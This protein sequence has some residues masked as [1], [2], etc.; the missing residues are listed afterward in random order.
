MGKL[1]LLCLQADIREYSETFQIQTFLGDIK[2][3]KRLD[4]EERS[5]YHLKVYARVRFHLCVSHIGYTTPKRYK[6]FYRNDQE[7][8]IKVVLAIA[9]F[10]AWVISE[11]SH[12]SLLLHK[13]SEC[14][15]VVTG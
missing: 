12:F 10:R 1:L 6:D 13:C 3:Q 9:R 8:L 4:Y 15:A 11:M 5:F 7:D 2:L 14:F